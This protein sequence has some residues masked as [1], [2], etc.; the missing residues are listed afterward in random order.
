M[1]AGYRTLGTEHQ[2]PDTGLCYPQDDIFPPTRLLW[3]PTVS[4]DQ[5][6]QGEDGD[7]V[8]QEH[9]THSYRYGGLTLLATLLLTP[10]PQEWVSLQPEDMKSLSGQV[11]AP[12]SPPPLLH[13]SPTPLLYSSPPPLLH[14]SILLNFYLDTQ[15]SI[16]QAQ[17]ITPSSRPSSAPSNSSPP[18]L[19]EGKSSKAQEKGITEEVSGIIKAT[20]ELEQDKMETMVGEEEWDK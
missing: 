3:K 4:G 1:N 16:P 10:L 17:N 6:L 20:E 14:S 11:E 18:A 9:C 12:S 19:T 7:T 2:T 13:S 15:Q 5:W 8:T